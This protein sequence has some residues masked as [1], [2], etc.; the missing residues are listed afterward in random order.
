MKLRTAF[1]RGTDK[2]D[3]ETL[4]VGH[5]HERCFAIARQ[6][7]DAHLFCVHGFVGLKIV[8]RAAGTPGPCT[9][10]APIVKLAWLPLVAQTNNSAR[11]TRTVVGLNR[12]RDN[13]GIAPALC[14]NLLLP[15]WTSRYRRSA[16]RRWG[17]ESGRKN[18]T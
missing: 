3:S 8:E 13:N 5:C 4:I 9:Q 2:A 17:P 18:K 12:V 10:R 7:F 15:R 1:A 14:Q 16:R 11:Q 6:A